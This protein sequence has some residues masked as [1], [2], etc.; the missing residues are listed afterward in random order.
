MSLRILSACHSCDIPYSGTEQ[1]VQ[2]P[3]SSQH[4]RAGYVADNIVAV[5]DAAAASD[6]A[7]AVADTEIV[8]V[9][10]SS[11]VAEV[12]VR[13]CSLHIVQRFQQVQKIHYHYPYPNYSCG[14]RRSNRCCWTCSRCR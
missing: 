14:Y 6:A 3:C 4:T 8:A 12:E 13:A 10:G 11:M 1:G 5:V 2:V 9:V 7:E